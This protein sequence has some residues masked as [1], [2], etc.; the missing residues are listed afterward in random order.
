MPKACP[1]PPL[2]ARR[3]WQKIKVP[4]LLLLL[5]TYNGRGGGLLLWFFGA[6]RGILS[7]SSSSFP[8]IKS[9]RQG[10]FGENESVPCLSVRLSHIPHRSPLKREDPKSFMT[11]WIE[12][13]CGGKTADEHTHKSTRSQM[14]SEREI[15]WRR[16]EIP[17]VAGRVPSSP[18]SS[19]S[20]D[21]ATDIS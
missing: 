13:W 10:C 15:E 11:R 6:Q 12:V 14:M 4:L 3:R 1:F 9:Q 5:R 17:V 8:P 16:M 21:G 20:S 19:F 18:F 7:P 2:S